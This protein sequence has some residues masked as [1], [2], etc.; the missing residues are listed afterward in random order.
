MKEKW[1]AYSDENAGSATFADIHEIREHHSARVTAETR[2]LLFF[3]TA[4]YRAWEI[5]IDGKNV[6]NISVSPG[7]NACVLNPGEHLVEFA[8]QGANRGKAGMALSIC[9]LAALCVLSCLNTERVR[10]LLRRNS[11]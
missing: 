2:G 5:R 1:S 10:R 3:K 4:F 8:Y 7:F 6:P 9:V 11:K